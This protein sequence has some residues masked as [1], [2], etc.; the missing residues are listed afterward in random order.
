MAEKAFKLAGSIGGFAFDV[1]V[2][3][4]SDE[5]LMVT[6]TAGSHPLTL[7]LKVDDDEEHINIHGMFLGKECIVNGSKSQ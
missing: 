4:A 5:S 2:S 3:Q 6:G 1:K 7:L